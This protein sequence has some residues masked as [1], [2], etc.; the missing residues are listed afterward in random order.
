MPS[1]T[2]DAT[3]VTSTWTFVV[4]R[5]AWYSRKPTVDT[6]PN[7]QA[8]SATLTCVRKPAGWLDAPVPRR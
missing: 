8:P 3:L 6:M 7:R 5:S 4:S 1:T 2:F